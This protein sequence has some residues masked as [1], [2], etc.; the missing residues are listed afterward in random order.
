MRICG[1]LLTDG[2]I[3]TCVRVAVGS[4]CARA[5]EEDSG[6]GG[7]SSSGGDVASSNSVLANL[8]VHGPRKRMPNTKFL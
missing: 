2:P 5:E 8:L 6:D 3:G 4:S 1:C 7:S